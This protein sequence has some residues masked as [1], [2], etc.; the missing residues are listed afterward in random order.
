MIHKV[1]SAAARRPLIG[2]F[3]H[4]HFQRVLERYVIHPAHHLLESVTDLSGEAA[5][6]LDCPG[7]ELMPPS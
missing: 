7:S 4:F 3:N 5:E 2:D 1:Q 6:N